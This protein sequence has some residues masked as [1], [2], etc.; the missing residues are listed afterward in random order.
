VDER[1]AGCAAKLERAEE[2]HSQL[3]KE[4]NAY[5]KNHPP[6]IEGE[7]RPT[8]K[9]YVLIARV[10]VD[11]P[12][13]WGVL[14]GDWAHN[15]RSA[16]DLLLWQLVLL[17]GGEPTRRTQFPIFTNR[18]RYRLWGR[19]MIDGV[20]RKDRGTLERMQPYRNGRLKFVH[21]LAFLAWISNLDKHRE[22]HPPHLGLGG[23]WDGDLKDFS[24]NEDAG[25]IEKVTWGPG[26]GFRFYEGRELLRLRLSPRGAAPPVE[27]PEALGV[28]VSFSQRSVTLL[29][30][31]RIEVG[32][33]DVFDVLGPEFDA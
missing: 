6:R 1:L 25:Q 12:L 11:P 16:L 3:E 26:E 2:L 7:W 33:R 18:A 29:T 28:V 32:V 14:L 19:P 17:R 22:V 20:K 8:K 27:A 31:D 21:P 9:Q 10:P 30:L 5:F 23:D 4:V 13:R 15:L 24:L